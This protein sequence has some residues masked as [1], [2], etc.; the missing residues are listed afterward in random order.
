M[1]N[2]YEADKAHSRLAWLYGSSTMC[3]PTGLLPSRP[4]RLVLL[5][6]PGVGKGTQAELLSQMLE[7]CPL[8]TGDMFRAAKER[9]EAELGPAMRVAL[10][11]MRRG[12]L[13]PDD[14]VVAMVRER[15]GC[16]HCSY[17]FLLDGF[18]RTVSQAEVLD[19]MLRAECVA[20]DAVVKYDLPVDQVIQRLS[21]RRTCRQCKT[22]FHVVSKPP[23]VDGVCDTCG[24]ELYQRE[25]D[26][27]E[28]IRVRLD[29]YEKSTAPLEHYYRDKGL[30]VTVS[31]EGTAEAIF[32]RTLRALEEH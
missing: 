32:D 8:S 16:L 4:Y 17:G 5:G 31:A 6:A 7:A 21:G 3:E 22:T 27:P 10:S 9:P 19:G 26:C 25:D 20:L 30:L 2:Q 29:A 28:A 13:V 23:T 11:Y 24:G 1:L 18:P 12:E 14:T 15:I